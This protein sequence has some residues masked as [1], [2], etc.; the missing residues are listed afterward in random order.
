MMI[1]GYLVPMLRLVQVGVTVAAL[2]GF[3]GWLALHDRRVSVAA[4]TAD[5]VEQVK[6]GEKIV[7][8]ANKARAAVPATGGP[9]RLRQPATGNCRDC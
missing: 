1:F 8:K 5:R 9:D 4:V 6:Q 2:G 7:E 3:F